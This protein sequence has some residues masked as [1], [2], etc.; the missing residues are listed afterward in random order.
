MLLPVRRAGVSV[1]GMLAGRPTQGVTVHLLRSLA[2]L[3]RRQNLSA[4]CTM[5]LPPPL[6]PLQKASDAGENAPWDVQANSTLPAGGGARQ[7][8]WVSVLLWFGQAA[9]Q[10][11]ARLGSRT[12][13]CTAGRPSWLDNDPTLPRL[14]QPDNTTQAFDPLPGVNFTGG[15]DTVVVTT[16]PVSTTVTNPPG[17]FVAS[18]RADG[19]AGGV[20]P[21]STAGSVSCCGWWQQGCV[22]TCRPAAA[23]LLLGPAGARCTT[24]CVVPRRGPPL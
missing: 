5:R 22:L 19:G 16:V 9:V 18:S 24:S 10:W 3:L 4:E 11:P 7:L 13:S 12:G 20:T 1:Q 8:Q 23:L 17:T 6:P 21:P 15:K 14:Q 2:H